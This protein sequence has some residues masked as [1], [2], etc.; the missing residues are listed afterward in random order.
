MDTQSVSLPTIYD[1]IPTMPDSWVAMEVS[2]R[3]R[4]PRGEHNR[5]VL[6]I[7]LAEQQRRALAIAARTDLVAMMSQRRRCPHG[8]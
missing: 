6:P 3:R 4:N 5:R 1:S 2:S 8:A 7:L